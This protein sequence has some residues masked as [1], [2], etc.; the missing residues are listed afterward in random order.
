ML[1]HPQR[2]PFAAL[3]AT[4]KQISNQHT[5]TDPAIN[6]GVRLLSPKQQPSISPGEGERYTPH[7]QTIGQNEKGVRA[8]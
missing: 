6:T 3:L 8:T 5:D 2:F 1:H 4:T 7:R